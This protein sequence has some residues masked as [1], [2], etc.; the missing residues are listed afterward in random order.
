MRK[1]N[2]HLSTFKLISQRAKEAKMNQ[3]PS[4]N[5]VKSRNTP[6]HRSVSS[7]H[8][9][10]YTVTDSNKKLMYCRDLK[11]NLNNTNLNKP[12]RE[13]SVGPAYRHRIR[14][15]NKVED[16]NKTY[17]QTNLENRNVETRERINTHKLSNPY[18]LNR[19]RRN[20][21]KSKGDNLKS[22]TFN[23][24][25]SQLFVVKK[26]PEE[27][28]NGSFIKNIKYINQHVNL[29]KNIS[30]KVMIKKKSEDVIKEEKPIIEPQIIKE[31][32]AV[33]EATTTTVKD[34]KLDVKSTLHRS[35]R[36]ISKLLP[37]P[38]NSPSLCITLP[39][40]NTDRD[41]FI[42]NSYY[43]SVLMEEVS[44]NYGVRNNN[45]D[46]D[47]QDLILVEERLNHILNRL[48]FE[49]PVCYDCIDWWALTTLSKVY[50]Q[51]KKYLNDIQ[52]VVRIQDWANLELIAMAVIFQCSY[53]RSLFISIISSL[54]KVIFIIHQTFLAICDYILISLKE[55][56]LGMIPLLAMAVKKKYQKEKDLLPALNQ[57]FSTMNKYIVSILQSY[58]KF[59]LKSEFVDNIKT[60]KIMS[61]D[62][63]AEAFKRDI[64]YL[65][66]IYP[67]SKY[68][69]DLGNPLESTPFIRSKSLFKYSL[70]LDLDETLIYFAE[71]STLN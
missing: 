15:E 64:S 7:S 67:S 27:R 44:P 41:S 21:E 22:M 54:K 63:I 62:R 59:K 32:E 65:L 45:K 52:L 9:T 6:S 48:Y 12:R 39:N 16:L 53:N 47:I 43:D 24:S 23:T 1:Q 31:P 46:I 69:L 36:S 61:H 30:Q 40:E 17:V 18:E 66:S 20:R 49:T 2:I 14:N 70:I 55:N 8:Q 29:P 35:H 28:V 34:H 42:C 51:I 10:S 33:K 37:Q 57:N 60:L 50:I 38:I 26:E 3:N 25:N 13:T 5:E 68:S 71:V 19:L 56:T 4:T 11:T 58:G